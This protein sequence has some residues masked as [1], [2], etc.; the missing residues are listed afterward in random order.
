MQ[1]LHQDILCSANFVNNRTCRFRVWAPLKN[2]MVLYL[3]EGNR[4]Q[5]MTK[6]EQGYFSAVAE[7]VDSNCKYFFAPDGGKHLPDPASNF[8]PDG[9]HG[10][11]QV[12][13][14]NVF[15]WTD[16]SWKGLP[17]SD[18]FIYELHAGTFTGDGTF[19][20]I[21]PRIKDLADIGINAIE[22]MPV[23]QFPGKRNWGYDGV[24]PYAVQNSYGGPDD[25]KKLVNAC[26]ENGVAVILDVVYNHV[27]PEGNCFKEYGPYFTDR[28]NTPW[29]DAINF[30]GEWSDGVREYFCNNALYWLHHFHIDG[31][32]LD[33]IHMAFD[34][35][36]RHFWNYMTE[37]VRELQETAG[38]PLYLIAESD[39]NSP[40]VVNSPSIGGYGFTAQWLDDFHHALYVLLDRKGKDRYEDFGL[41]EQLAK[42]YKEGFVH[43]G[44]YVKFRKRKFGIS[45]AAV[46]GDK[47]V[48]FVSN[49]DQ[50][51][52]RP[53]GER[54]SV[55]VN[56]DRLKL[57]VAAL[58]CSACIPMFFMGDEYAE[59]T[60]F[61]YFID[62]SDPAL[63][64]A[65]RK[66]RQEEF[67]DFHTGGASPDPQAPE[68]FD[69]SV[70]RWDRRNS[71][72]YAVLLSWHKAL[73]GL[74]KSMPAFRN[75]DK[76]HMDVATYNQA[77]LVIHRQD[78]EL[79]THGLC[80]FNFSEDAHHVNVPLYGKAWKKVIAS[81]DDAWAIENSE[82]PAMK[83]S[84]HP[85]D[86]V[87][88]APLTFAC[89]SC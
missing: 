59:E 51:G 42:A 41:I 67:K 39:L 35:G 33:A 70:L 24:F 83:D 71:A 13:D 78:A 57:A 88:L 63:I 50:I 5:E 81:T 32:R 60:P 79:Q 27:G 29:G 4:K 38:R 74:R 20:A 11:S 3:I 54:L 86:A 1:D 22:L 84:I 25:L 28:Y 69:R 46:P 58:I 53:N 89:Y 21:I 31:L 23:A 68:T 52:N 17:F 15:Q 7:N 37:K 26:H 48:V 19:Q 36:S 76:D 64:E 73:I 44:Q 14:H 80:L 65:V 6:D 43:S 10:C 85:G 55:L 56:F 8:Q 72:H 34:N 47:F 30:D 16:Q 49:H 61:F 87:R 40:R 45:S 75:P 18:L 62:H 66:G 82:V 77:V 2:R 9:V 12:I